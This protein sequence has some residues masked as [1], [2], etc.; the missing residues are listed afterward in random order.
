MRAGG[1][2]WI[3]TRVTT[4]RETTSGIR[5][6]QVA[7]AAAAPAIAIVMTTGAKLRRGPA[8]AMTMTRGRSDAVLETT[9]K[10]Q[11]DTD[12]IAIT[13]PAGPTEIATIENAIARS[14]MRSADMFTCLADQSASWFRIEIGNT[15]YAAPNRERLRRLARFEWSPV[16]ISATTMAA[17]LIHARA[18]CGICVNKG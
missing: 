3:S 18:T 9:G 11:T 1:W 2:A 5:T 13:I 17:P 15:H 6:L 12:R 7:A 16:V 4:I 8:I 10:G 14:R